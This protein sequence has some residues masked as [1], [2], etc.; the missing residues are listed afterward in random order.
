MV[1]DSA[2][3]QG[4]GLMGCLNGDGEVEVG[5]PRRDT[6]KESP[7]VRSPAGKGPGRAG[8]DHRALLVAIYSHRLL[9]TAFL[10]CGRDFFFGLGRS[11]LDR[12]TPQVWGL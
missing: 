6:S 10:P 4:A 3:G 9:W 8:A 7:C 1:V 2:A 12:W 11:D 5:W